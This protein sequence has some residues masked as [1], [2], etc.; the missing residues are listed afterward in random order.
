MFTARMEYGERDSLW[1]SDFDF[2]Y[3]LKVL[4]TVHAHPTIRSM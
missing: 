1:A 3:F 2:N 4:P